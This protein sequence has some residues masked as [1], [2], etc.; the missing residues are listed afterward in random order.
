VIGPGAPPAPSDV[1]AE[2]DARTR[3]KLAAQKSE[4]FIPS[5]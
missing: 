2:E 3:S 4:F 1:T 5:L